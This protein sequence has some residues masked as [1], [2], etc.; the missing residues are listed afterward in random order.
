MKKESKYRLKI[1]T[2]DRVLLEQ[3]ICFSVV[4]SAAG[5][6]G[7]LP[8]HAPLLGILEIGVL[9]VR[10]TAGQEFGIFV[11]RGFF[12]ISHEGVTVVARVAELGDQIDVARA[13][14]AQ[15]RAQEIISAGAQG[16]D[17][18]RA[19]DALVRSKFRIA[20]AEKRTF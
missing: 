2:Q 14:A 20:V 17:F 3:D 6:V 10:D 18:E 11:G 12:M 7:V 15:Q 4:P 19:Q 9:K 13:R 16:M 1:V 8:G 5:P